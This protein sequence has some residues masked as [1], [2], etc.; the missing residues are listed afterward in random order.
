MLEPWLNFNREWPIVYCF[1]GL[2]MSHLKYFYGLYFF[3]F[4]T[5]GGFIFYRVF[6]SFCHTMKGLHTVCARALARVFIVCVLA[7]NCEFNLHPSRRKNVVDNRWQVY[8]LLKMGQSFFLPLNSIAA[9]AHCAKNTIRKMRCCC[10]NPGWH[11]VGRNLMN[12][13]RKLRYLQIIVNGP[14]VGCNCKR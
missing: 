13:A 2:T 12:H 14:N 6:L 8:A 11:T 4:R 3:T 7:N 10:H 1:Y 5:L 9:A